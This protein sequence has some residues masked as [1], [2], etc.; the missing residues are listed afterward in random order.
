M[1]IA[2]PGFHTIHRKS[3][4]DIWVADHL[5]WRCPWGNLCSG[6]RKWQVPSSMNSEA[7]R[8][9]GSH[10]M[11]F[12]LPYIWASDLFTDNPVYSIQCKKYLQYKSNRPPV[13]MVSLR[14]SV[15]WKQIMTSAIKYE[16]YLSE[17]NRLAGS[18][19]TLKQALWYCR[20]YCVWTLFPHIKI[21]LSRK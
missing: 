6:N 15:Q 20:L 8:L 18:R 14:K 10:E 7:N 12:F 4:W 19:V 11:C 9:P 16:I 13:M 21:L 5:L 3:L 2:L 1:K 17:A